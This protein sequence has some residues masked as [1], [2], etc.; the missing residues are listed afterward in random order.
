[1]RVGL[2]KIPCGR[3]DCGGQGGSGGYRSHLRRGVAGARKSRPPPGTQRGPGMGFQRWIWSSVSRPGAPGLIRKM[4]LERIPLLC[5]HMV[6]GQLREEPGQ[7]L[8]LG[9][10]GRKG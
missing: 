7:L 6:T 10:E 3:M 4:L 5:H 8:S 1:M 2:T 9:S